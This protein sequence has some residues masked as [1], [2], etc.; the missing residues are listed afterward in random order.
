MIYDIII[1]VVIGVCYAVIAGQ[2]IMLM[3]CKGTIKNMLEERN[4]QS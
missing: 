1:I 3:R 4:Q 2:S